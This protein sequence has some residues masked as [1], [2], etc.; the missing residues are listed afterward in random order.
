[1]LS[2]TLNQ[3]VPFWKGEQLPI[4]CYKYFFTWK[5]WFFW[6]FWPKNWNGWPDNFETFHKEKSGALEKNLENQNFIATALHAQIGFQRS[7]QSQSSTLGQPMA[8]RSWNI[9]Y[10]KQFT[11][12]KWE[13]RS[14][15]FQILN[16]Q[17]P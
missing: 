6:R 2:F 14:S 7:D 15:F 8:A 11:P 4:F 1:M 9:S 16:F 13:H 3:V 17:F 10:L 5:M 12:K